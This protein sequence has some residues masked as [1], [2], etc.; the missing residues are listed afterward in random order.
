MWV[1]CFLLDRFW[2]KSFRY[3]ILTHTSIIKSLVYLLY[4]QSPAARYGL[5]PMT[6]TDVSVVA[7]FSKRLNLLHNA[8]HFGFNG[9]LVC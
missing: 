5:F 8:C 4:I 1:D 7:L 2:G 9:A 3:D 6:F